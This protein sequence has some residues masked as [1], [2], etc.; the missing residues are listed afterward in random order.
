M[1]LTIPIVRATWMRKLKRWIFNRYFRW[2][3]YVPQ[4]ALSDL[5][6]DFWALLELCRPFTMTSVER[7][8]S[9]YKAVEYVIRQ[10]IPGDFVECGV[11]RGGSVMMMALAL[12][13]FGALRKIHCF[14]TFEGMTPPTDV[15]AT[16][17]G[18]TAE[19]ILTRSEKREG[20]HVWGIAALD[21]VRKNIATTG[22]AADLIC[23]HRGRVEKTIPSAAPSQIAILRLDTDWYEST[24]HELVHLYPRLTR[25]G[26]L[27]IDD[28]GFWRGSQKATDEYLAE[29]KAALM[30]HRIDDTGRIAIKPE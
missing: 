12:Q 25:G 3:T 4:P 17:T 19:A 21:L 5:E 20:V 27:I 14:D 24:K 1:D 6:A 9:L 26:V 30:L 7:L 16:R 2:E 23:F 29:S 28:Y 10:N 15:D 11:W 13:K 8:Y 18:E 22:Y